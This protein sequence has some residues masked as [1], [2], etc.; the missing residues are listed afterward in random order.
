MEDSDTYTNYGGSASGAVSKLM[1]NSEAEFNH[2]DSTFH[3][4]TEYISTDRVSSIDL[5]PYE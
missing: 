3:F 1:V 4:L 5:L 2:D